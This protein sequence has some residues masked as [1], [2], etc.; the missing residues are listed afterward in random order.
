MLLSR[1]IFCNENVTIMCV[2]Q[3]KEINAKSEDIR[4][5]MF[6]ILWIIVQIVAESLPISSS[7]HILLLQRYFSCSVLPDSW[8]IDFMLHVPT[9]LILFCYFFWEWWGLV[10]Y[11]KQH[12]LKL[13]DTEDMDW[14]FHNFFH[15]S[16]FILIVDIVTFLF[17]ISPIPIFAATQIN[18]LPVGFCIT[19]ACLYQSFFWGGNKKITWLYSD[20]L[21]LGCVQA[22]SLLP[23]IS[24]FASTYTAGLWLGYS[25]RA[26][27]SLSFLIQFP[28]LI[29]AFAKAM[30]QL[31]ACDTLQYFFTDW[32]VWLIMI[33][34]SV[35]SYRLFC[36]V[37]ILIEQ[38]RLWYFSRYMLIPI[39]LS[40]F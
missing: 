28:L 20:A 16:F 5:S 32:S 37:A 25:R 22:I 36:W 14:I 23:G 2:R 18:F 17:W 12:D 34:A 10:M 21:V 3:D 29:A 11:G 26:S 30:L 33:V 27:F 38:N 15:A 31:H 6:V 19:A 39:V 35:I 7:G 8:M 4:M 1:L 13:I 9:I 40:V 24:R